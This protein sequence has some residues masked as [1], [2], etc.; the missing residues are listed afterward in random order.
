MTNLT[1][2]VNF[3]VTSEQPVA[4]TSGVDYSGVF[5]LAGAALEEVSNLGQRIDP[6]EDPALRDA[7]MTAFRRI[8]A[9]EDAGKSDL[10]RSLELNWVT[11]YTRAGG[12]VSGE[13]VQQLAQSITGRP[14]DSFSFSDEQLSMQSLRESP[15]YTNALLG[16][17]AT[18]P[19]ATP[20]ELEASAI[21]ILQAQ[22]GR[23]AIIA[24]GSFNFTRE[25]SD[26]LVAGISD[27]TNQLFGAAALV[28][29]Q[30]GQL[31]LEEIDQAAVAWSAQAATLVRPANVSAEAWAP[32]QEKI[33][34]TNT[35]IQTIQGFASN[36]SVEARAVDGLYQ[37]IK[38]SD[39]SDL[40]KNLYISALSNSPE[41]LINTGA[42]SLKDLTRTL[43]NLDIP[44]ELEIT[45]EQ[46]RDQ[47]LPNEFPSTNAAPLE[48]FQGA[49]DLLTAGNQHGRSLASSPDARETWGQTMAHGLNRMGELAL[50]GE[51]ISEDSLNEM[52]SPTFY[53]NL[54][55]VKAQDPQ[56]GA[57]IEARARQALFSAG[58]TAQDQMERHLEGT[59]FVPDGQGGFTI[60]AGSLRAVVPNAD[61]SDQL[62]ARIFE[63]YDSMEDLMADGGI[64]LNDGLAIDNPVDHIAAEWFHATNGGKSM[65][66]EAAVA[67]L[68]SQN[69]LAYA[70]GQLAEETAPTLS[71]N[72]QVNIPSAVREDTAFISELQRVSGV[73]GADPN[74]LLRVMAFETGGTFLP[75]Q[76]AAASNGTGLIQFM[77]NTARELGTSV[78]SLA[79]MTRAEQMQYVE[80][81]LAPK[82][83]NV[84]NPGFADLYMAV[85]WP[86]AVGKSD[87]YVLY[88]RGSR[89]YQANAPLDTNSDGTVTRGEAWRKAASNVASMPGMHFDQTPDGSVTPTARPSPEELLQQNQAGAEEIL[90]PRARPEEVQA[91]TPRLLELGVSPEVLE[92]DL[93]IDTL[94]TQI[95]TALS[96]NITAQVKE[97]L[98]P[99]QLAIIAQNGIDVDKLVFFPTKEAAAAA[100]AAG[101]IA[102]G[103]PYVTAGGEVGIVDQR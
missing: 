22:E 91:L 90:R 62:L 16:A 56:L 86:A 27:F 31:S 72:S 12:D 3:Q 87:D 23:E 94:S 47:R 75:S 13:A 38:A 21:G 34:A 55:T 40:D 20:D 83:R 15:Q 53:R 48:L 18:N 74:D 43:Q 35:L 1:P 89:N 17:M 79:A 39:L 29:R 68:H 80:N 5:R 100:F 50:Q 61:V 81:Y 69:A 14:I 25:T 57:A 65:V 30:G 54:E 67:A 88:R 49:R 96:D 59:P 70:M 71:S 98:G 78:D 32:V 28:G 63:R 24:A 45:P 6:E 82:L 85:L 7:S 66:P 58:R 8:R 76:K 42:I 102:A 92:G 77:P 103:T 60:T 37:A 97:A 64:L 44:E 84:E 2:D 36:G 101:R 10:A 95:A 93:D 51:Y 11:E 41:L 26:A 19:D 9:A 52:F 99:E 46:L 4:P 33:N 73:I